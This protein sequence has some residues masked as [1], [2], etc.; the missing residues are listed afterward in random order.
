VISL[1]TTSKLRAKETAFYEADDADHLFEVRQG[2]LK[3][4]Q[5]L[6]EGGGRSPGSPIPDS[7]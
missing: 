3:F 4:C 7:L 1:I 5:L 2:I 6:P